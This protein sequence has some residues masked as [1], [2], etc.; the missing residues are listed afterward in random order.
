M[1]F[2]NET[3]EMIDDRAEPLLKSFEERR[4]EIV[5]IVGEDRFNRQLKALVD[6]AKKE[7]EEGTF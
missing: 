6:L 3:K 1:E 2:I 4:K 7:K 5:E